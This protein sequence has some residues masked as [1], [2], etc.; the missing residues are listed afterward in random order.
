MIISATQE[1]DSVNVYT[2]PSRFFSH[3]DYHRVLGRVLCAIQQVCIGQS[4]HISQCAYANPKP[5]VHPS[6]TYEPWITI[7]FSKSMVCFYSANKFICILFF[8]F[9]IPHI[10][11]ISVFKTSLNSLTH[12]VPRS[13]TMA[14]RS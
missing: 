5:P 9:L 11:D 7:S 4:F 1:S 14:S 13:P 8:F 2:H 3:I 6:Y 10:S 12:S